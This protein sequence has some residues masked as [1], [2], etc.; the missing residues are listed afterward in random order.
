MSIIQSI[1]APIRN[2]TSRRLSHAEFLQCMNLLRGLVLI[3]FVVRFLYIEP[4]P[5]LFNLGWD[6]NAV[7]VG[8]GVTYLSMILIS[9]IALRWNPLISLRH[10][11][12][13]CQAYL[14]IG[15]L[16]AAIV[17]TGQPDTHL[18]LFFFVP[19]I[20]LARVRARSI[21]YLLGLTIV[22]VVTA[23]VALYRL[24]PRPYWL[25]V[26]PSSLVDI[27]IILFVTF[28]LSRSWQNG[29]PK[30]CEAN[31]HDTLDWLRQKHDAELVF[32]RVYRAQQD[33][34]SLVLLS[35]SP[36][37]QLNR[38]QAYK[39]T[40]LNIEENN[41]LAAKAF[42]TGDEQIFNSR[43]ELLENMYYRGYVE[44]LGLQ[45]AIVMP[46]DGPNGLVDAIG[47]FSIY[48]S[49]PEGYRS[50]DM[51]L[52]SEINQLGSYI[53]QEEYYTQELVEDITNQHS[54]QEISSRLNGWLERIQ[55][56]LDFWET[57]NLIAQATCEL[58]GYEASYIFFWDEEEAKYS[59]HQP[60]GCKDYGQV[61]SDGV[62]SGTVAI[63]PELTIGQVGRDQLY[64]FNLLN[65]DPTW[66]QQTDFRDCI[67]FPLQSGDKTLGLLVVGTR[68]DLGLPIGTREI[69]LSLS[70][71]SAVDLR[72]CQLLNKAETK[73][74]MT[75]ALSRMIHE[76]FSPTEISGDEADLYQGIAGIIK[77]AV[78]AY[79]CSF[80]LL[81]MPNQR[82]DPG[83]F[84]I[85]D[86]AVRD[87]VNINDPRTIA[88]VNDTLHST[89]GIYK[90]DY[91]TAR[92]RRSVY[93]RWAKIIRT[94]GA[95]IQLNDEQQGIML[96]NYRDVSPRIEYQIKQ[97]LPLIQEHV[98]KAWSAWKD[99][100]R[101]Q[102]H[103]KQMWKHDIHDQ[104]NE[105]QFNVTLPLEQLHLA[106]SQSVNGQIT[107]RL[108]DIH[109]NA[110]S[111]GTTL[112]HI[113]DDMRHPVLVDEGLLAALRYL[114]NN[115][116]GL[117]VR[118]LRTTGEPPAQVANPIYRLAREAI[119]NGF[120]HGG[121]NVSVSIKLAREDMAMTI[122]DDGPGLIEQ[123]QHGSGMAL[124]R[125]QADLIGA[126]L[127][128]QSRSDGKTGTSVQIHWQK[129]H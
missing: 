34:E 5:E 97:I 80:G 8:L 65:A 82:L 118:V 6:I 46:I 95:V 43:D 92:E 64:A 72:N 87:C 119:H 19:F 128:W 67:A 4:H 91:E 45:S 16:I 12:H 60:Y 81:Q 20:A 38:R 84:I 106:A 7:L 14:E 63:P 111:V 94:Y 109:A 61:N 58:A 47:T 10:E 3:I 2:S 125:Y 28:I 32:L 76:L 25:W 1:F 51:S 98:P 37:T 52:K 41:S 40:C 55:D 105:L 31:F 120:K 115:Y 26:S 129:Q 107:S 11:F 18:T 96:I 68:K 17:L 35:G 42:K 44:K 48:W 116:Q 79:S 86:P 126:K 78:Q 113:M 90:M 36:K 39:F 27:T 30:L 100:S 29:R 110:R 21:I 24:W 9:E 33:D 103:Q 121:D 74:N 53:K 104:L 108:K 50:A 124:M 122:C 70:R 83:T 54:P 93:A 66:G 77:D 69:I 13:E 85:T 88:L 71:H 75:E 49:S 59:L 114:E 57:S 56:N 23:N 101:A 123:G 112:K 89:N 127:V 73:A 22:S 117:H 99:W 15:L 62:L 102:N